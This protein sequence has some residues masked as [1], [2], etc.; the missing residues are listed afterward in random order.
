M[1][2]AACTSRWAVA[3]GDVWYRNITNVRHYKNGKLRHQA[4]KRFVDPPVDPNATWKSELSGRLA[5][6]DNDIVTDAQ[7][8]VDAQIK[9]AKANGSSG[10]DFRF[11]AVVFVRRREVRSWGFL[12][13]DVVFEPKHDDT[14]HSNLVFERAPPAQVLSVLDDLISA[15]GV[16]TDVAAVPA[17]TDGVPRRRNPILVSALRVFV[18]IRAFLTR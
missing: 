13:S 17:A 1:A 2:D 11:V 6:V 12:D 9:A 3:D 18:R 8:R 7:R 15:L 5:S 14:A 16:T 10:A 4:L